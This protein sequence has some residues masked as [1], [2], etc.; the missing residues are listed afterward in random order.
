M[1]FLS[2]ITSDKDNSLL[3][4]SYFLR[5]LQ[6]KLNISYGV[7]LEKVRVD[8]GERS[9]NIII[10]KGILSE[11]GNALLPFQ[12]SPKI[13]IISNPT[14]FN[15]FGDIVIDSLTKA[16][17][18][19]S[20]VIIPDGEEYKDY[21]WAYHLLSELLSQGLDRNSCLIALG[22]G[23]IGDITGFIASIYMRGIHF[24]QLPTTLL[25][26]VDSSVGGKTGVNHPLGKN[27]IGTFYQ[28]RLVFVDTDT[29][30]TLPRRELLCGIS[31]TIKYGII[32]DEELFN[33]MEE[34]K[35]NI[36][37]LSQTHI[38]HIIKRSCEIKAQIVSMDERESG[39]RAILNYGH[40]AGHAIETET[41][42]RSFLHGEAVAIGMNLEA[43]LSEQIGVLDKRSVIR[44]K[45]IIDSYGLPSELPPDIDI[46]MLITHM[47]LDKK[48]EAGQIKIILPER[49]G[50]IIIRKCNIEDLKKYL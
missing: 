28:P 27:M 43:R 48:A 21:F 1:W 16:G 47:K 7:N 10:D 33:F 8:L 3:F 9:Y 26:Q 2:P 23:V 34:N 49:I 50:K 15:L 17:F 4:R 22:G 35:S 12:F 24:V 29:L 32:W 18:K 5:R 14:V 31:E 30:K 45:L 38:K 25:S 19:A 42:Y 36:L 20:S 37:D 44:I 13:I 40:T 11:I 39:L 6:P 46:N 41:G